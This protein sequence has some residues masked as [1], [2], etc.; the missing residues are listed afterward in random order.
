VR[1]GLLTGGGDVPGLN[2]VIRAVV[3]RAEGEYGHSVIG[4]RNGWKGLA[5]GD[6]IELGRQNIRN[7]LPIGGTLLGTARYH[8]DAEDGGIADVMTTLE[9]ERIDALIVV[10]G[11]GTLAATQ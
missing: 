3:K 4:F 6:V 2:A 8:P 11:D 7:V 5:E 1:I 9:A 10:G